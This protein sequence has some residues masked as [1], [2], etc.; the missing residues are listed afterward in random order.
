MHYTKDIVNKKIIFRLNLNYNFSTKNKMFEFIIHGVQG[1]MIEQNTG[2]APSTFI[3]CYNK[4]NCHVF[5]SKVVSTYL[6]AFKDRV[7]KTDRIVL[8]LFI[9]KKTQS[10]ISLLI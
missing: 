7:A 9:C 2:G 8:L 6:Q 1:Q 5:G 3:P 4:K 10:I